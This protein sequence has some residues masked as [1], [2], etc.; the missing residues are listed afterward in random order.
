MFMEVPL[1]CSVRHQR[2]ASSFCTTDL[3]KI[4][5]SAIC[6]DHRD[7]CL[8][9]NAVCESIPLK[10]GAKPT[11][12]CVCRPG[13]CGVSAGVCVEQ[14]CTKDIAKVEG[15]LSAGNGPQKQAAIKHA[16]SVQDKLDGKAGDKEI[17]KE[18]DAQE[19]GEERAVEDT[20]AAEHPE[21]GSVKDIQATGVPKPPK[22][23]T[24]DA[25][26]IRKLASD[27]QPN[28]NETFA[29]VQGIMP[30]VSIHGGSDI[31][32]EA[33]ESTS[34]YKIK[35]LLPSSSSLNGS[36]GK[37]QLGSDD[38]DPKIIEGLGRLTQKLEQAEKLQNTIGDGWDDAPQPIPKAP[39]E[40]VPPPGD[41][42]PTEQ[43][44]M[45]SGALVAAWLSPGRPAGCRT[46]R[47]V[48]PYSQASREPRERLCTHPRSLAAARW[49]AFLSPAA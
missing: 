5:T 34:D 24:A 49:S 39:A 22:P 3:T 36:G 41:A 27:K 11:F 1:E 35:L 23:E 14:K 38:I 2:V 48:A 15:G 7:A 46:G 37:V 8:V 13:S 26:R 44:G 20:I 31:S 43:L 32:Q 12:H 21:L 42:Q 9:R 6:R 16:Q 19:E 29:G 47:Q 33:E 30:R 4:D 18:V 28:M 40:V 17:A 25:S 10:P 45:S